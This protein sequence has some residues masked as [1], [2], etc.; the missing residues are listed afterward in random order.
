M[1]DYEIAYSASLELDFSGQSK[2]GL[3]VPSMF[4]RLVSDSI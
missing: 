3:S 4:F 1:R 2:E